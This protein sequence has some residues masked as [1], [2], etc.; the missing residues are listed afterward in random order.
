M[1]SEKCSKG[2][3]RWPEL[4]MVV[5]EQLSEDLHHTLSL[6]GR[7]FGSRDQIRRLAVDMSAPPTT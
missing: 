3:S 6:G 7:V 4:V 5:I 1:A 2:S